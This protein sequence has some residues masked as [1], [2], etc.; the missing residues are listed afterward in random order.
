MESS[1]AKGTKLENQVY[2][3]IKDLLNQDNFIVPNK[4]SEIFKR[5]GYYSLKRDKEIIFDVTIETKLPNAINT[6]L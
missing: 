6:Q 4:Y 2:D 1:T 5:K 3:L